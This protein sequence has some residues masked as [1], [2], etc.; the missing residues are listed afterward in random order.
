MMP[1]SNSATAIN[2][3][4]CKTHLS[5]DADAQIHFTGPRFS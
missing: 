5:V 2:T 4:N 3:F 1:R